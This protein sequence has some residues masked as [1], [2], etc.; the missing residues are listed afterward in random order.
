[1]IFLKKYKYSLK[2]VIIRNIY[3][4]KYKNLNFSDLFKILIISMVL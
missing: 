3:I 2:T 4:N 1:M